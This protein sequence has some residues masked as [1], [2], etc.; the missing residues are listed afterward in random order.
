MAAIDSLYLTIPFEPV[1]Y[2]YAGWKEPPVPALLYV[3]WA[4]VPQIRVASIR[5]VSGNIQLEFN[6]NV[7]QVSSP[8]SDPLPATQL[9]TATVDA[10][11]LN[12]GAEPSYP[13][14][15]TILPTE[16]TAEY[17]APPETPIGGGVSL[18]DKPPD[19]PIG[20]GE[21]IS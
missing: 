9:T 2:V 21:R 6:Q 12:I 11:L 8:T 4:D 5:S 7:T 19:P 13:L 18:D 20:E 1:P 14:R 17:E 16:D 3:G 10:N 15:P